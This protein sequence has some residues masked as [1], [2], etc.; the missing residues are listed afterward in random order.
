MVCDLQVQAAVDEL[1]RGR[2]YHVHRRA[3][4]PGGKRLLHAE[5][6]CRAR[7]VGEHDLYSPVSPQNGI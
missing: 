2:T 5:I 1:Y 4:L 6:G 3:Q 7:K